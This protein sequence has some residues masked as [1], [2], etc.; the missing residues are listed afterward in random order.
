MGSLSPL[1]SSKK[2]FE[3]DVIDAAFAY[4]HEVS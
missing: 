1:D 2:S 4:K 3:F